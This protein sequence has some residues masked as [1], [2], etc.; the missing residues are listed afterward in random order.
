MSSKRWTS[1]PVL[2]GGGIIALV[3]S[4]WG[5][6]FWHMPI[7]FIYVF[8]FPFVLIAANFHNRFVF[9]GLWAA[10]STVHTVINIGFGAEIGLLE[11]ETGQWASLLFAGWVI[12]FIASERRYADKVNQRRIRELEVMNQTL[13]GISSELELNR[14]LQ[15][16]VEKAVHLLDVTL[17]E[18]LLFDK[19]SG[20]MTIVAQYPLDPHQ[21]GF[22]MKPGEGAM[23]RVAVTKKPLI[24]NDY[25]AFVNSLADQVTTGVE[26]T[27][28]VPLLKGDELI[29]VLGVA[30]HEKWSQFTENDLRLLTVFASQTVIAIE[31]AR[32]YD[33]VQRMAF[34]DVLTCINN[35]RRLF[36]LA[37]IEFRRVQRY[38]RPMSIMLI[39]LDRFKNIND[40][41]GHSVGDATLR[42]FA[43]ICTATIRHKIDI[44]GRFGGEEF[45]II[46]P[47]TKLSSALEAAKRLQQSAACSAVDAGGLKLNVTFSAGIVSFQGQESITLDQLIERADRAMY[48]AKQKRNSLAYWDDKDC[49]PYLI[50]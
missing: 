8:A 7:W 30:R 17:G 46:Y 24:L 11:A 50:E 38:Q 45:A 14:L 4:V 12:Y 42:W 22:K 44:V 1:L 16:I 34:T 39:D 40:L 9:L 35:R 43:D 18:L 48:M 10:F 27:M 49:R 25:K 31:N 3:A 47:E 36:E 32:L 41:H 26:S 6:L 37:D 29:G 15:V 33:E 13:S 28:D 23:G 5:T 20:E 2:I 21:I 19:R